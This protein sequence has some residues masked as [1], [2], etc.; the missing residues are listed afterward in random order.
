LREAHQYN[1]KGPE[2]LIFGKAPDPR[3]LSREQKQELKRIV[4]TGPHP[5]SMAWCGRDASSLDA[6]SRNASMSI[7]T[8]Y[9]LAALSRSWVLR[10]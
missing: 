3:K 5:P 6:T 1:E 7:S 4:E 10:A 9:R 8:R 2:G